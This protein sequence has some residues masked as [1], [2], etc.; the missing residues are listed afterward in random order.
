MRARAE[1]SQKTSVFGSLFGGSYADQEGKT[2]AETPPAASDE[3]VEG[4]HLKAQS[5][6][7][8]DL[9][10]HQIVGGFIE[11]AR[12]NVMARFPLEER[13]FAPIVG[14]SPFVP[15]GHQHLFGLGFA[16]FWQGITRQRL[17][18][19]S[20]SSKTPCGMCC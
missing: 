2:I 19:S 6:Q 15:P 4:E 3:A 10:R 20:P 13:H 16:R 1:E 14:M 12:Q 5:L 8:L 9:W 7:Y 11:P 17:F 18:S